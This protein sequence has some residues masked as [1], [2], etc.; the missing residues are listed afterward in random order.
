[1]IPP[2]G[3]R[4]YDPS[5]VD[6]T[7]EEWSPAGGGKEY[8]ATELVDHVEGAILSDREFWRASALSRIDT[9]DALLNI[10]SRRVPKGQSSTGSLETDVPPEEVTTFNLVRRLVKSR[11]AAGGRAIA[12]HSRPLEGGGSKSGRKPSGCDLELAVEVRLGRWVDLALQAKKFLP[13]TGTYRGW[14][15]VQ[16]TNL[17]QWATSNGN[18]TPGMLL[19]NAELPPFGSPGSTTR[20]LGACCTQ[21]KKI[22]GS[23]SP[24]RAWSLPDCRTPMDVSLVLD[25]NSMRGMKDPSPKRLAGVAFPLECIF[26]PRGPVVCSGVPVVKANAPSWALTLLESQVHESSTEILERDDERALEDFEDSST[27]AYSV[28]LALGDQEATDS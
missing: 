17:I 18:R 8:L 24:R 25:Q 23:T 21:P 20:V 9:R 19:Y 27:S 12:L 7:N 2:Y 3:S 6:T 26:C 28:V 11:A 1:M 16:N 22:D 4:A 13:R 15:P 14:S 10:Y 5:G